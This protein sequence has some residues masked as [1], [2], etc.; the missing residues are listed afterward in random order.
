MAA[1]LPATPSAKDI[2][3]ANRRQQEAYESVNAWFIDWAEVLRSELPYRDLVRLGLVQV[4]RSGAGDEPE[5]TP[6]GASTGDEL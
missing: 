6:E 3:Q 1:T 2:A 5:T 4:R